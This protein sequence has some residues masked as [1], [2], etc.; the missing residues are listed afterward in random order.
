MSSEQSARL[1]ISSWLSRLATIGI[2]TGMFAIK[3]PICCLAV[4]GVTWTPFISPIINQNI[5]L[6]FCSSAMR[7]Y[8]PLLVRGTTSD[9]S[10]GAWNCPTVYIPLRKGTLGTGSDSRVLGMGLKVSWTLTRNTENNSCRIS[11]ITDTWQGNILI[12]V[13]N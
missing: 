1:Y 8:P 12:F 9:L 5:H 7:F 3:I 6:Y 2:I 10:L 11:S 13:F 4:P